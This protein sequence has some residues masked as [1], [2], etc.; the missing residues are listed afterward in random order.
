MDSQEKQEIINRLIVE[1]RSW[2]NKGLYWLNCL[3]RES[4][5]YK[6][7]NASIEEMAIELA[8]QRKLVE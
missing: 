5:G 3:W 4:H 2:D 8:K 6:D 1:L 7:A